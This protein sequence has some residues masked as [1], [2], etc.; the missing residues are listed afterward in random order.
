MVRVWIGEGDWGNVFNNNN[1]AK[2]WI[3]YYFFCVIFKIFNNSYGIGI[4]RL[5]RVLVV[6]DNL[7]NYDFED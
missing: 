6:S 2:V 5:E 7:N 3:R 1:L 4:D